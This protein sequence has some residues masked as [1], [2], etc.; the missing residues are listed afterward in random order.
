[1]TDEV[2]LFFPDC[3]SAV[4]VQDL[5][6]RFLVFISCFHLTLSG[7]FWTTASSGPTQLRF[8]CKMSAMY[9]SVMVPLTFATVKVEA[10]EETCHWHQTMLSKRWVQ[11]VIN[12]SLSLSSSFYNCQLF[13]S[14]MR[15]I[16]CTCNILRFFECIVGRDWT[17]TLQQHSEI[18]E[19]SLEIFGYLR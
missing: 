12:P 3:M 5:V 15:G 16:T 14:Q 13:P 17:W 18:F 19:S 10:T 1:M 4:S 6:V 7:Y 2:A 8:C 11:H 9:L